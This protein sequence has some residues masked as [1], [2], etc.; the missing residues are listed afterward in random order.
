MS[1]KSRLAIV[2][3]FLIALCLRLWGIGFGLPHFYHYDE[4]FYINTALN[5]GAGVLNNPPY[6]PVGLS[7]ILFLEYASY[8]VLGR[9][10]GIFMSAQQF[11][12]AYRADPTV[13]YILARITSAT[14]GALTTLPAFWIGRLL[15]PQ[16]REVTGWLAAGLVAIS[17]LFVRD[18]HYGVPDIAMSFFC[19]LA[20]ALTLWSIDCRRCS[21]IYLA[22]L[23]AGIAVSMKWTA[24]PIILAVLFG[25]LLITEKHPGAKDCKDR[26]RI[27]ILTGVSCGLGFVLSSPQ[28]VIS[29]GPY[30]REAFGQ[31]AAGQ[32]GGFDIWLVDTLPGW[33]FYVKVLSYGLGIP[34]LVLSAV[35][36]VGRLAVTFTRRS[37]QSLLLLLFPVIYFLVMGATRHYFARYAL[38]LV[39]FAAVFAADAIDWIV[40]SLGNYNRQLAP[41]AG[42]V[43]VLAAV[44]QPL[45]SSMRHD[46]LL[47]R[48]DTRTIAK[49]WIETNLPAGAK[50]ALDWQTHGPPLASPEHTVP[51]AARVFDVLIVGNTGLSEHP[52]TWY[53]ENGFDYLISS[54]FISEIS[55]VFPEQDRARRTFQASLSEELELIHKFSPATTGVDLPFIFD[56]IYGPAISLWQRE[57]PGPMLDIYRLQ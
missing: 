21:F 20:V 27:F 55:L 35:G 30:I 56:E 26:M 42:A 47:T 1:P 41:A 33:L 50:I 44:A 49:E 36:V 28:V 51:G 13:F 53:R 29:P 5:L 25:S 38:P 7:N 32:A 46:I 4:H 16:R 40:R 15:G 18:S 17:F 8:F 31:L 11:E 39:P 24:M 9:I 45:A 3:I 43:L 57:R 14:L 34:I 19:A 37:V 2:A 10:R 54:S 23:V 12:A 6:A 22:G 52:I 48:P